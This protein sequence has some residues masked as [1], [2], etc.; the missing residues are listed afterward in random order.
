MSDSQTIYTQ[1]YDNTE[2]YRPPREEHSAFLEIAYGCSWAGCAFCDFIKDERLPYTF[3]IKWTGS[4]GWATWKRAWKHFNPDGAYL[5]HELERRR[6]TR[7]FDF[8]GAYG[9][10]RMLRRQV[11]G[12]NNSWAIRWNASLFLD[13]ILS[14]NVGRS[15]VKNKGMDGSG[16]NSFALDPYT[17]ILWEKPL[18]LQKIEPITEN[19][20]ARRLYARFYARTN[21]KWAKGVRKL[22]RIW[23]SLKHS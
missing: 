8:G 4:W 2:F 3:L 19:L 22:R 5:L 10:T 7:Q 23:M 12:K 13:G 9:F 15:L 16:T 20:E 14:L 18:E 1:L 11:E 21:S 17:S 6:L